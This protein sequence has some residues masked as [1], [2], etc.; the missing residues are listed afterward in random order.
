L[1]QFDRLNFGDES[2]VV[3]GEERTDHVEHGVTEAT[4]VHDVSSLACLNRL[5]RLQVDADQLRIG[6]L[7]RHSLLEANATIVSNQPKGTLVLSMTIAVAPRQFI[8]SLETLLKEGRISYAKLYH[9]ALGRRKAA[10]ETTW[11]GRTKTQSPTTGS[12]L[13]SAGSIPEMQREMRVVPVREGY[14][15]LWPSRNA[16]S[17]S[18]RLENNSR[19]IFSSVY[20]AS[21]P[22]GFTSLTATH[23]FRGM[24]APTPLDLTMPSCLETQNWS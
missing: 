9:E 13:L 8:F 17:A 24:D 6:V 22:N 23:Y 20:S 21:F 14:L 7:T 19:S 5:V 16:P 4:D 15:V 1:L 10:G 12:S 2:L 11:A 18:A 3:V